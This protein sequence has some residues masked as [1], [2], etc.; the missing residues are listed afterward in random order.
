MVM[1]WNARP[2]LRWALALTECSQCG[3]A[4][5][6]CATPSAFCPAFRN[7]R[8]DE[9]SNGGSW[10]HAMPGGHEGVRKPVDPDGN[11]YADYIMPSVSGPGY[12]TRYYV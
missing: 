5:T 7:E 2:A 3:L 11:G 12:R 10:S 4:K 1:V 9:E 6:N 8:G